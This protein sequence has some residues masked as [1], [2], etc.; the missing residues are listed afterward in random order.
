LFLFIFAVKLFHF[1]KYKNIVIAIKWPSLR[2]K[3]SQ[4]EK[5]MDGLREQFL[6]IIFS[7]NKRDKKM[8]IQ[9]LFEKSF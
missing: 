7:K 6:P 9:L 1:L 4:L 8:Y 3:K 2:A 5:I